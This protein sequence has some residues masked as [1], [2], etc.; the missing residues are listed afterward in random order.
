LHLLTLDLSRSLRIGAA[1]TANVQGEDQKKLDILSNDIMINSLR[2]CGKHLLPLVRPE[3][4]Q[5]ARYRK[6]RAVGIGGERRGYLH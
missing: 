3:L 5:C 4:T 2:A 1:G 6:D